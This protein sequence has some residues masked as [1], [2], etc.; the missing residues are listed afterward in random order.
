MK[1]VAFLCFAQ[2]AVEHMKQYHEQPTSREGFEY[3]IAIHMQRL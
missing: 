1:I 2:S 3:L